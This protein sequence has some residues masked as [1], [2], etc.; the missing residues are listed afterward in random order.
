MRTI[1]KTIEIDVYTPKEALDNLMCYHDDV[2]EQFIDKMF[3]DEKFDLNF[4]DCEL[5]WGIGLHLSRLDKYL[6]G[7]Y[8][9]YVDDFFTIFEQDNE[10]YV[11]TYIE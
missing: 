8:N 6:T 11:L 1:T 7:E 2:F 9:Y 5:M 10:L 4:I 3:V